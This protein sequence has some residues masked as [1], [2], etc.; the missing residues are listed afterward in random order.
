LLSHTLTVAEKPVTDQLPVADII[1]ERSTGSF[2]TQIEYA[3]GITRQQLSNSVS[4]YRIRLS[5]LNMLERRIV[6]IIR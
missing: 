3:A 5:I 4:L 1:L 2:H 6:V